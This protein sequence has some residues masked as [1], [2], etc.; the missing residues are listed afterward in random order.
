MISTAIDIDIDIDIDDIDIDIDIAIDMNV[1]L[2]FDNIN[3]SLLS[4]SEIMLH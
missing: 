3:N 2:F 4:I 1:L